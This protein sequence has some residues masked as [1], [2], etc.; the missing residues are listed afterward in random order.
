MKIAV[1]GSIGSGKSMVCQYLARKGYSLFDCDE[2]NRKLLEKGEEGYLAIRE[3]FPECFDGEELNKKKLA[4]IVFDDEKEKRKLEGICHPLILKRLMERK[5][6][7]L[8]A[9]VPLLFEAG[10]EKYFDH[11]LLVVTDYDLLMERL[12][13]RGLS[14]EEAKER[15]S[16][17][18]SVEEKI[19]RADKIIYNN[20]SLDEL[21]ERVDE[22]LEE[23][24]C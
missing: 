20:G 1:T 2:E 16:R 6:D 11:D 13:E 18:M 9:E 5:E 22:W 17:Q 10:W 24:K 3:A 15:F 23:L 8:F 21:Y 14:L 4:S 7:P 19:K 12:Q